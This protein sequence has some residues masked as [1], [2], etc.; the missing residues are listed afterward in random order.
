MSKV[1]R[2][3]NPINRHITIVPHFNTEKTDS[4][5]LLP[6]DFKPQEDRY[7]LATV[8]KVAP[9]CSSTFQKLKRSFSSER[10]MIVVDRAMIEEIVLKDKTYYCVLENY[11]MGI[12]RG[13]DED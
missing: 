9:D 1:L 5:V 7:I 10:G 4:G 13:L 12:F 6:E 2:T 3:L 8:V 11:V